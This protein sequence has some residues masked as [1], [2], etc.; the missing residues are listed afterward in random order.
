VEAV[1]DDL[2]ARTERSWADHPEP[3]PEPDPG[4]K[5]GQDPGQGPAPTDDQ[6]DVEIGDTRAGKA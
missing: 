5:P 1:V 2:L 3:D 6:T 4:Q